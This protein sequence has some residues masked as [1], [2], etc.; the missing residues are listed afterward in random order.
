MKLTRRNFLKG[1][2]SLGLT[3]GL[4]PK[5]V[6][7]Q[8]QTE[9]PAP[10]DE[11]LDLQKEFNRRISDQWT[12]TP[13]AWG[14]CSGPVGLP[15]LFPAFVGEPCLDPDIELRVG[16]DVVMTV[17]VAPSVVFHEV[18]EIEAGDDTIYARVEWDGEEYYLRPL[19]DQEVP[20][21]KDLPFWMA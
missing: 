3:L 4:L 8:P 7:P 12:L 6:T 15:P 19:E 16:S 20:I 2:G 13:A 14:A 1:L 5:V 21:S 18:V 17:P 10:E 11:H 9:R